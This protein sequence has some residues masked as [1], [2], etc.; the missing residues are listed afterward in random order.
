M[1]ATDVEESKL[2]GGNSAKRL[3]LDARSTASVE[4]IAKQIA[5]EFGAIDVLVNC[6]GYVHHGIGLCRTS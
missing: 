1:I 3:K 6:A 5:A 2:A 4:A